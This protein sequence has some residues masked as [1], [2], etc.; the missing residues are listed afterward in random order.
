[1]NVTGWISR[2]GKERKNMVKNFDKKNNTNRLCY[3]R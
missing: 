2:Y 1:M 3:R